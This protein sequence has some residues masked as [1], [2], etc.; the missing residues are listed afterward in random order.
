MGNIQRRCK[1]TVGGSTVKNVF[2]IGF[3]GCGKSTVAAFMAQHYNLSVIEMDHKIEEV[4]GMSI[5]D[6][7]EHKGEAHFRDAETRLLQEISIQDSQVISCGGG[8]VLR[9]ENV[10][11]M[12]QGGVVVYLT[13]KPET[14]L[15]RVKEDNN[16]PLLRGN[17][18]VSTISEMMEKR[19]EKYKCAADITVS[20][21]GK[22]PEQICG[23]VLLQ[24]ER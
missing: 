19:E 23:E 22:T 16:R 4:E 9:N 5:P 18:N 3:M 11:T 15:E 7:F 20:T 6:I 1:G 17:K 10:A 13:A 14:I 12:K 2:L 24:L 21:D 8:V